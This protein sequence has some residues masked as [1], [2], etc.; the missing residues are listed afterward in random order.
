MK[1]FTQAASNCEAWECKATQSNLYQA[2]ELSTS[3]SCHREA[4][5]QE[6]VLQ[7]RGFVAAP[8]GLFTDRPSSR[9]LGC[10]GLPLSQPKKNGKRCATWSCKQHQTAK[11]GTISARTGIYT[12]PSIPLLP[13]P[14]IHNCQHTN[15]DCKLPRMRQRGKPDATFQASCFSLSGL[16]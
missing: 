4:Q 10:W 8:R 7:P 12:V 13:A 15:R 11:G 5:E 2:F 6:A 9:R 16:F 1:W 3:S 14:D